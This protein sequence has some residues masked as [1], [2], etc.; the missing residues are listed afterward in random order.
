MQSRHVAI[1]GISY[2][3]ES[4]AQ[5]GVWEVV[6]TDGHFTVYAMKGKALQALDKMTRTGSLTA[7]AYQISES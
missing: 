2:G 4:L 7:T 1:C 6:Q 5:V 3:A